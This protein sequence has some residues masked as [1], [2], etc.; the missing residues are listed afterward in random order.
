MLCLPTK[1]TAIDKTTLT[2]TSIIIIITITINLNQTSSPWAVTLS[3]Q[4][5]VR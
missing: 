4:E 1:L 2:R 3:W 5:F